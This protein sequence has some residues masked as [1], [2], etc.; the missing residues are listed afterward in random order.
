M[1]Y[2]YK[3]LDSKGVILYY[4]TSKHPEIRLKQHLAGIRA[5]KPKKQLYIFCKKNG[6]TP[7]MEVMYEYKRR[8]DC[9]IREMYEITRAILYDDPVTIHNSGL[10]KGRIFRVN[11]PFKYKKT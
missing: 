7:T 9:K 10:D 8:S 6:I 4:G 1:I 2:V 11:S 3:L 5:K